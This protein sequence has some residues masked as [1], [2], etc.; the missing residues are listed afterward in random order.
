V[1]TF[2][3]LSCIAWVLAAHDFAHDGLIEASLREQ[4]TALPVNFLQQHF[5]GRVNK[6]HA[7]KI[8]VK[9]FLR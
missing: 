7:A 1:R 8:H 3:A 2:A 4:M 9:L 6:T 5:P